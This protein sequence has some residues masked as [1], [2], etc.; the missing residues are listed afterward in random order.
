MSKIYIVSYRDSKW[1]EEGTTCGY[2]NE[3]DAKKEAD[4]LTEEDEHGYIYFVKPLE[5]KDE[6]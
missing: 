6:L 5:M 1:R 3:A 4:R 2:Y